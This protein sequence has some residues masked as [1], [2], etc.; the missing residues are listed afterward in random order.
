[1]R[2]Q[3]QPVVLTLI[4][5]VVVGSVTTAY[6]WGEPILQ[7]G[8]GQAEIDT[9]EQDVTDLH[10]QIIQVAESGEGA[11]ETVRIGDGI[12]ASDNFRISVNDDE[13]AIEI[14]E[15]SQNVQYPLDTWIGLEGSTFQNISF[16]QGDY[17]IQGEDEPG[18]L[19]VRAEGSPEEQILTY[20]SE[21]R[22]M[23]TTR[24][25]GNRLERIEL[26]SDGRQTISEPSTIVISNEGERVETGEDSVELSTGER[27]E[28]FNT[29]IDID[30]R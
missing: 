18:I 8:Q 5:T 29:R 21:F 22:N 25:T 17:A 7:K 9:L 23:F 11:S 30:L 15:R 12:S 3:T 26:V 24:S 19:A 4:A 14:T 27:F 6:I 10:S 16:G 20:R 13:N 28:R 2:G 1:M